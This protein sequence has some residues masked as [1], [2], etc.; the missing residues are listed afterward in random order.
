MVLGNGAYL[1]ATKGRFDKLDW[2]DDDEEGHD[3]DDEDAGDD[4][5]VGS[6]VLEA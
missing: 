4:K 2:E 1:E 5:G 6:S 3:E